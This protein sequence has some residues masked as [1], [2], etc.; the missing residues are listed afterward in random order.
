MKAGKYEEA[1]LNFRNAVQKDYRFGEAYRQLGVS[2]FALGR[3]AEALN[4]LEQARYFSPG[5]REVLETL[6]D[7][8]FNRYLTGG[9][10]QDAYDSVS[11][12]VSQILA[13]YPDSAIGHRLHASLLYGDGKLNESIAEFEKADAASPFDPAI[14]LPMAD[15]LRLNNRVQDSENTAA[16]LVE[17]RPD[18]APGYEWLAQFYLSLGRLSDVERILKTRIQKNPG[19]LTATVGIAEFYRSQNRL[20]EANS[21][22]DAMMVRSDAPL[23]RYTLAAEFYASAKDWARAEQ[24]YRAAAVA[25]PPNKSRYLTRI[26][27][28]YLSQQQTPQALKTLRE[29]IAIKKDNWDA[30][31]L[32]VN[33]LTNSGHAAD[34]DEAIAE[35][36]Q[37]VK[38][39]PQD[40]RF[41]FLLANGLMAK[42][43]RQA[44][45]AAYQEAARVGAKVIAPRLALAQISSDRRDAQGMIRYST[46]VLNINP[47]EAQARL[48][49]AEGT[50]ARG[51]FAEA[52]SEI[53]A[54]ISDYPTWTEARLQAGLLF[55]AEKRT[56]RAVDTFRALLAASPDDERVLTA[57][58]TAYMQEG[59]GDE[60]IKVLSAEVQKYPAAESKRQ[61]LAAVALKLNNIN[62]A[63]QQYQALATAQP[64]SSDYQFALGNIYAYMG[65]KNKAV[66]NF[67][68]AVRLDPTSSSKICRLGIAYYAAGMNDAADKAYARATTLSPSDPAVLNDRAYFLAETGKDPDEAVRLARR[69]LE[70]LPESP[71]L[72]DTLA[73]SYIAKGVAPEAIRILDPLVRSNPN[74]PAFRYHL[75]M[76]M[77]RNGGR[78][79][80]RK[81]LQT[82]LTKHPTPEDEQK[83]RQLLATLT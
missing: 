73:L 82:S 19:D 8:S 69:A 32:E 4:A 47:A 2:E 27:S 52:D 74:Q 60:A 26:A 43:D 25:D 59:S 23:D 77:L 83:I 54:L 63:L 66:E 24:C 80:A 40:P 11:S 28:V 62:I 12:L 58:A 34:I 20:P 17:H 35:S 50:M 39:R 81:E 70:Q 76:A 36:R 7:V 45:V 9:R 75:A 30:R 38:E 49:H 29:A 72:A 37:L 46:E 22:V 6:A 5:N 51:N 48:I 16:R 14:L 68:A 56:R 41:P 65:E 61:L 13:S 10:P 18:F 3:T 31:S 33:I 78:D 57:L 21:L 15:A 64:A 44:A 67:E 42:G 79:Q 1:S 71:A 53:S 55:L